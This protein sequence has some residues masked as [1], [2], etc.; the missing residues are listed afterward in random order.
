MITD[1]PAIAGLALAAGTAPE[2]LVSDRRAG[3]GG[4]LYIRVADGSLATE[5]QHQEPEVIERINRY[6]G[7]PAVA[8][9]AMHQGPVSAGARVENI[10]LPSSL[11]A[12]GEIDD[13]QLADMLAD[14]A[15]DGLRGT[16]DRLSRAVSAA[17]AKSQRS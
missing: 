11:A 13:P 17:N 16:L 9:L 1:W 12:P 3:I 2:K 8:R 15:D 7:Y 5:L 14:V 6:F 10:E 4:T